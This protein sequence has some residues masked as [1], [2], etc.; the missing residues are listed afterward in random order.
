MLTRPTRTGRAAAAV[1][2]AASSSVSVSATS[3]WRHWPDGPE[4]HAELAVVEGPRVAKAG[5]LGGDVEDLAE[6]VRLL[7]A[8][9]EVFDP[10]EAD[11]AHVLGHG[12]RHVG[13][14]HKDLIGHLRGPLGLHVLHAQIDVA[15]RRVV[16]HEGVH[17]LAVDDHVHVRVA[18]GQHDRLR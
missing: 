11:A 13:D 18:T 14:R 2:A 17:A 12:L 4:A 9:A 15:R 1:M 3:G 16:G 8:P 6:A 10:E 7:T 5:H